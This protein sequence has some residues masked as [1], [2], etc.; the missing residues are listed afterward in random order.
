MFIKKILFILIPLLFLS[1]CGMKEEAPKTDFIS[2][3]QAHVKDRIDSLRSLAKDIGYM[4]SYKSAGSLR[5]LAN[6]PMI[7][8][9]SI[10]TSYDAKVRG[11]DV[12]VSF[13]DPHASYETF[14]ASGS[15][16]AKE[17]AMITSGGDAFFRYQDLKNIGLIDDVV[18]NIFE[19]YKNTWLSLKQDELED[20]LSGSTEKDIRAYKLSQS[21]SR[22]TL[23]DIE[24]YLVK[25]PL[26]K[27]QKDL[28]MSGSLHSYAVTLSKE[29]IVAMVSEFTREATGKD[30]APEA[31]K[32]LETSLADLEMNAIVGLDPN[33]RKRIALDG[34]LLSGSG[35][36]MR[37]LF[38]GT[39]SSTLISL[40]ASW[41]ALNIS[42]T[43]TET[44]YQ[45][46]AI[47][48]QDGEE[49]ARV[50]STIKKDTAG[51]RSINIVFSAPA[52]GLS[53]TIENQENPDGT[54]VGKLN[55]GIGN[56]SWNGK[57]ESQNGLRELHIAW[58]MIGSS[59]ALDLIPGNDGML[60][61]P[62][63]VKSGDA[64]LTS[65][66][67]WLT[68][69]KEE[70]SLIVDVASPEDPKVR[71]RGEIRI[72]GKRDPW[73]GTITI[74]KNTKKFKDFA[75]EISALSPKEDPFTEMSLDTESPSSL[76]MPSK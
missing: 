33:D 34:T 29:N 24:K 60:R 69:T 26:W 6:I 50:E 43:K 40:S 71:S 63:L 70:F 45:S 65:A 54:F 57:I 30:I 36:P 16:M 58:A 15:V 42:N 48:V 67:V 31:L 75:D 5:M 47:L 46:S 49:M 2:M 12:E 21:I 66:N 39:T 9:G 28:G 64:I 51:V 7:L 4:E 68:V 19:K 53:V 61:G 56:V 32:D 62:L 20:S 14:L 22:M 38:D 11:Q 73:S 10:S 23:S 1:S 74:P 37:I 52:Q 76:E 8:S 25:Y 72:T 18:A 3:Y 13:M 44:G 17:I 55:A 59:L 35:T 27:E 41:N